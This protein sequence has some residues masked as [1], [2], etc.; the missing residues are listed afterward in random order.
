MQGNLQHGCVPCDC[1]AGGSLGQ[2]CNPNTGQCQCR[3][4]V[5]GDCTG[6]FLKLTQLSRSP[7]WQANQRPLFPDSLAIEVRG[8]IGS[9]SRRK[10]CSLRH[11]QKW[12]PWL[13]LSWLCCILSDSRRNLP[14]HWCE[15][16]KRLP[17]VVPLQKSNW[18]F[19]WTCRNFCSNRDEC[20]W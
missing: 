14:G 5:E 2:S 11:W 15:T 10:A 13:L 4:Y 12:V 18:H 17:I 1:D 8:R 3:S 9:T 6:T 16:C 7:L 20:K 19:R